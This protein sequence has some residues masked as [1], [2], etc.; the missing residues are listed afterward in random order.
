M[1]S[2]RSSF[3]GAFDFGGSKDGQCNPPCL[4]READTVRSDLKYLEAFLPSVTSLYRRLCSRTRRSKL[5][6]RSLGQP[7]S[8]RQWL[9][10]LMCPHGS[11][12]VSGC[13]GRQS[14]LRLQHELLPPGL[15]LRGC[16]SVA[17][18]GA[19][20]LNLVSILC[21]LQ[22]FLEQCRQRLRRLSSLCGWLPWLAGLAALHDRTQERSI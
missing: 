15:V 16:R 11:M 18:F 2:V 12:T 21:S 8:H 6:N 19:F 10:L 22:G 1:H 14:N 13:T 7:C 4:A 5:S 9:S 20:S 17:A 3:I